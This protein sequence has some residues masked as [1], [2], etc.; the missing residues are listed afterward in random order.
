MVKPQ[1]NM[2]GEHHLHHQIWLKDADQRSMGDTKGASVNS[3]EPTEVRLN[4]LQKSP[5]AHPRDISSGFFDCFLDPDASSP[6]NRFIRFLF[7]EKEFQWWNYFWFGDKTSTYWDIGG[8]GEWRRRRAYRMKRGNSVQCSVTCLFQ[9]I[10]VYSPRLLLSLSSSPSIHLLMSS[11]VGVS[12][13]IWLEDYVWAD[14]SQV[15][16]Q[17]KFRFIEFLSLVHL[18]KFSRLNSIHIM[19]IMYP[20]CSMCQSSFLNV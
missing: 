1:I 19:Y 5:P 10:R 4:E 11:C 12:L 15:A 8:E 6:F 20:L 7:S 13:I 9:L 16:S 14:E 3:D 18:I 2:S 17:I